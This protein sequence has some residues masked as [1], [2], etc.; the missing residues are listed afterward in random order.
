M[1]VATKPIPSQIATI[2]FGCI[3]N[4]LDTARASGSARGM[5][6]SPWKTERYTTIA[7]TRDKP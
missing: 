6:A 1:E 7:A 4:R 3:E 2:V 5:L